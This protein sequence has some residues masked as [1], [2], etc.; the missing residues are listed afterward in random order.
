MTARLR[1]ARSTD[2]GTLGALMTE[3]VAQ[4]AW[5]PRLHS[6]A[7]DIAHAGRMIDA[8]WVTVAE[9]AAGAPLGFLAREGAYVHALFVAGP[10]RGTGLGR[11]LIGEAQ[12]ACDR[13]ELW[14]FAANS[15]ARRF[16]ERAGFA[17]VHLGDGRDNDEGLPDVHYRWERRGHA[18]AAPDHAAGKAAP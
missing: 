17:E 5:K 1:P 6:G 7:Q 9:D 13:L 16:Y 11:A 18:V 4:R 14:T 2:A 3:A 12:R 15:G 8:G 10:A